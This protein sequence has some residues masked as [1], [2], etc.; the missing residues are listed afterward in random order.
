M[1]RS[2]HKL[3]RGKKVIGIGSSRIVY[4]WNHNYVLK[5]AKSK[6]GIRCNR[7]E[8]TIYRSSPS[9]VRRRLSAVVKHGNGYR[10]LIMRKN[11]RKFSRTSESVYRI[12]KLRERFERY[13]IIPHDLRVYKNGHYTNLR[14]KHNGK[15]V[16]IDYGHFINTPWQG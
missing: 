12:D 4:D 3:M 5:V 14:L 10:W 11:V 2:I 16:V 8:V 13:G 7:T 9:Q 6:L 15:I 1:K